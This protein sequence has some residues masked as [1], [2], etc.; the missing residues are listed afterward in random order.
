MAGGLIS[1]GAIASAQ[2]PVGQPISSH[3]ASASQKD[4]CGALELFGNQSQRCKNDPGATP[5]CTGD[6]TP[7]NTNNGCESTAKQSL[8]DQI[9]RIINILSVVV[10]VVAIVIILVSSIRFLTAGGDSAKAAS[11]RNSL[12][13]AIIG[14][15]VMTL[16]QTIIH[17]VKSKTG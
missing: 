9:Q 1:F 7:A 15:A 2:S 4:A 14:I 10:G 3:F 13:Y 12:I 8:S 5:F 17:I 6:Q 11:A 16:A